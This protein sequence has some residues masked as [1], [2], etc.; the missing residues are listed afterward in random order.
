MARPK[1]QREEA[2]DALDEDCWSCGASL[3]AR[4]PRVGQLDLRLGHAAPCPR[5]G[6]DALVRPTLP[7]ATA[8]E[9]LLLRRF[10]S[11]LPPRERAFIV[12][13]WRRPNGATLAE[14]AERYGLPP[15]IL[16]RVEWS[17][18][19]RL[20]QAAGLPPSPMVGRR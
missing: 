18:T 10:V 15:L 17:V 19:E 20:R 12:A 13:R 3:R 5:C 2:P 16:Y 14:L 6:A 1:Q 7:L 9:R 4:L 8:G 11:E